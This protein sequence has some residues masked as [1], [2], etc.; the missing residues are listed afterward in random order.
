MKI[1]IAILAML[2]IVAVA[3]PAR[4][5]DWVFDWTSNGHV[6]VIGGDWRLSG[7]SPATFHDGLAP[8]P[9]NFATPS[10]NLNFSA[11]GHDFYGGL[12]APGNFQTTGWA[13]PAPDTPFFGG[14]FS[15]GFA[16]GTLT[17]SDPNDFTL[18]VLV[19]SGHAFA[20][21]NGVGHRVTAATPEPATLT[22]GAIGL[23]GALL[24]VGVGRPRGRSEHR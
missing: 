24:H 7:S 2:V 4:A 21:L 18:N 6:A 14:R 16:S 23:L 12:V 17:F 5:Q 19:G 13:V 1:T 9:P 15:A 10:S 20:E 22:V 11:N 8:L 3:A